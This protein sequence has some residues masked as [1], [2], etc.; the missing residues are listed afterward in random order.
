MERFSLNVALPPFLHV[1]RHFTTAAANESR[2]V[3]STRWVVET[4]NARLNQFKFL[5]NTVQISSIRHLEE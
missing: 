5:S 3:T 2:C 1:S 4:V